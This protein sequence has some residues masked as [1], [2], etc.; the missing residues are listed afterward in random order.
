[1]LSR[2]YKH[3]DLQDSLR[4]FGRFL[5]GLF[6]YVGFRTDERAFTFF[7]LLDFI[8]SLS[9]SSESDVSERDE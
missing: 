2:Y 6:L 3:R 1:M 9:S 4:F 8:D 7:R 5:I